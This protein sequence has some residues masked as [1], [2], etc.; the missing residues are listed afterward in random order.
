[1][2]L[3]I[4]QAIQKG[5]FRAGAL[6]KV[7]INYAKRAE[8]DE[9][10]KIANTIEEISFIP[11]TLIAIAYKYAEAG[12][13]EK[14]L[15]LLDHASQAADSKDFRSARG[16]SGPSGLAITYAKIGQID[17]ALRIALRDWPKYNPDMDALAEIAAQYFKTGQRSRGQ[18]VVS[19]M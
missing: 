8:Y 6:S 10:L 14:A 12:Q 16:R 15:K 19:K 3:E 7:A 13:K 5:P 11:E 1:L 2:A 17:K 18:R 4:A 9:A